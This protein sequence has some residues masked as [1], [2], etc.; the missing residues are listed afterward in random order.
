MGLDGVELVLAIEEGFQI[1]I[2][3]HEAE[4][5]STVGD[6]YGLVVS[7]LGRDSK[8]CLTSAAFYRTRRGIVGALGVARREIRP[9]TNLESLLPKSGRRSM[10]QAIEA[11]VGLNLPKLEYPWLTVSL[12]LVAGM[13]V[14]MA[15]A[16]YA[17]AGAAAFAFAAFGGA[18]LG[19]SLLRAAPG[20]AVA[21]PNAEVT[22]GDLAKDVLALNHASLA[23]EIGG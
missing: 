23:R 4:R 22:V 10:W 2:E 7:K 17:H 1:H 11:R 5:V 20:L 18:I 12:F 13:I 8:Q 6:L 3:D 14:G 16:V 9:S 21:I 19:G 15:S